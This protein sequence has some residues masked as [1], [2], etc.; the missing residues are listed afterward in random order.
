MTCIVGVVS[1]GTMTLAG[2]S[3]VTAGSSR[4]EMSYPKMKKIFRREGILHVENGIDMGYSSFL[5]ALPG[6]LFTIS[7]NFTVV[8]SKS[9]AAIGNGAQVARGVLETFGEGH[10][11]RKM[12]REAIDIAAKLCTGVGGDITIIQGGAQASCF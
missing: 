3:Q 1:G 6:C 8:L 4:S 5:V 2:D 9:Y 11:P 10:D 7:S 12:V